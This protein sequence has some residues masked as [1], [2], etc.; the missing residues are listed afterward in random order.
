MPALDKSFSRT[1]N[2]I[3]AL[4]A[5][6]LLGPAVVANPTV[7][8]NISVLG[9]TG[10]PVVL[11]AF[12]Q[13]AAN[14]A[15]PGYYSVAGGPINDPTG[16]NEWTINSW[17]FSVDDDPSGAGLATGAQIG[18]VFSVTNNRPDALN[19]LANHL[20]FSIM[21]DVA[22]SPAAAATAFI[23]SGSQTILT[24]T[25]QTNLGTLSALGGPIWNYRVNGS[26]VA[27][28]FGAGYTLSA[29]PTVP[30]FTNSS[31]ANLA[32]G[33]T[34]PLIGLVPT[35]LGIR[36]DFDLSP[37]ET[38]TFNGKF[39]FIPAP[40]AIGLLAIA[41]VAGRGRRRR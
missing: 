3:V 27:S 14:T 12:G 5:A 8:F 34:A 1:A 4:G 32:A 17:N 41:G 33:Q 21:V 15:T 18:S 39:A 7:N 10:G 16:F 31:N 9:G 23:G 24:T 37:G 2:V 30:P 38:V 13:L 20:I 26:D 40:G 36:L 22:I 25:D 35:S 29:S 6:M 11:P 19:P 28:L